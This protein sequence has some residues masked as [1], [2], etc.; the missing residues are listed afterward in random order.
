M[1]ERSLCFFDLYGPLVKDGFNF[2]GGYTDTIDKGDGDFLTKDTLW[3]FKVTKTAPNKDHTLQVLV[4]YIMGLHSYDPDFLSIENL[5]FY[6][7]RKN[8]VYQL[9]VFDIPLELIQ[10]VEREVIGYK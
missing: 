4:Y 6:N 3:D 9:P 10:T 7:P 5:G 2:L 8:I 1:V